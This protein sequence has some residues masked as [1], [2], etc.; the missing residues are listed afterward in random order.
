MYSKM[1]AKA[2]IALAILLLANSP[3]VSVWASRQAPLGEPTVNTYSSLVATNED[4]LTSN[5]TVY[6]SRFDVVY[7][8]VHALLLA[9]TCRAYK[10]VPF[11]GLGIHKLGHVTEEKAILYAPDITFRPP[12][13][14]PCR[15]RAC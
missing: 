14:P 7:S 3:I 8:L 11:F 13:L 12:R 4:T 10:L 15:A 6:F 9:A 5:G 2:F 1:V